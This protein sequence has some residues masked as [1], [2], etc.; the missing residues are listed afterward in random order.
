MSAIHLDVYRSTQWEL[1]PTTRA[2]ADASSLDAVDMAV[3]KGFE[4]VQDEGE[5]NLI[6]RMATVERPAIS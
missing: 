1:V 2:G 3:L 5:P 4:E 6:A